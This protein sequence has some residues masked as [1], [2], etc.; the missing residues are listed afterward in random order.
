MDVI[1]DTDIA[2]ESYVNREFMKKDGNH[3][4]VVYG[5]LQALFL[6][7]DAVAHLKQSLGFGNTNFEDFP[8]LKA[9][10][11]IRNNAIGH[12]TKRTRGGPT[13]YHY[14]S[15]ATLSHKGFKLL[16]FFSDGSHKFED[17]DLLKCIADQNK[18]VCSILK[19]IVEQLEKDEANY[20]NKFKAEKLEEA[21]PKTI[22]YFFEKIYESISNPE[23]YPPDFGLSHLNLV[24]DAIK[25]FQNELAKRDI[26]WETYNDIKYTFEQTEYPLS[27]IEGFLL[28]IKDGESPSINDKDAVIF[29]EN[30]RQHFDKLIQI[31]HEIDEEFSSFS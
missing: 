12:P 3:Y 31:A 26:D 9:I 2:I 28:S 17:I 21:F 24:R 6:Q 22:H 18:T 27:R 7:Q 13:S 20:K 11:D 30:S 8:E 14:I 19:S 29:W 4:L 23:K 25:N 1:E 15:R 10:R 5:L 16:S